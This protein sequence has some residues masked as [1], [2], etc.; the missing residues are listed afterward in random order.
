MACETAAPTA[1]PTPAPTPPRWSL[2]AHADAGI[3]LATVRGAGASASPADRAAQ[4]FAVE[5]AALRREA[6]VAASSDGATQLTRPPSTARSSVTDKPMFALVLGALVVLLSLVV[7]RARKSTPAKGDGGS[8]DPFAELDA[9]DRNTAQGGEG[10]SLLA[11]LQAPTPPL[12]RVALPTM[13]ELV[14]SR[15]PR[16]AVLT[17]RQLHL[18]DV[19]N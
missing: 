18:N 13:A 9:L 3:P 1:A 2:L 16:G 19:E 15:K 8:F 14:A 5:R 7:A 4:V 12:P 11:V 17:E 6:R 10:S